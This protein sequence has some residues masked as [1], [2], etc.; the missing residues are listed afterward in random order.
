[1]M[2]EQDLVNKK[3]EEKAEKTEEEQMREEA[4]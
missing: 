2:D 4:K 1:M 3:R